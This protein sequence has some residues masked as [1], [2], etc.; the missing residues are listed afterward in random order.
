MT[1]VV[2]DVPSPTDVTLPACTNYLES[3]NARLLFFWHDD[4]YMSMTTY[5]S[6]YPRAMVIANG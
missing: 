3:A 2:A 5:T 1:W 4:S 6:L